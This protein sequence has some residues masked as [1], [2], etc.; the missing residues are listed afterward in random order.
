M[1]NRDFLSSL[2]GELHHLK[3]IGSAESRQKRVALVLHTAKQ[4]NA[5]SECLDFGTIL[6]IVKKENPE[7]SEQCSRDVPRYLFNAAEQARLDYRA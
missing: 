1:T 4:I 6:E 3:K 7:L 5:L 2:E